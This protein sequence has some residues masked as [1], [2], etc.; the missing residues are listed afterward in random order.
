[1]SDTLGS[2]K[3]IEELPITRIDKTIDIALSLTEIERGLIVK[4]KRA[5]GLFSYESG[6]STGL[7]IGKNDEVIKV[8]SRTKKAKGIIQ[9]YRLGNRL[10][11]KKNDL[12]LLI[13]TSESKRSIQ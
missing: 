11:F 13:E 10:R 8:Y 2:Q 7:Q 4:F 9:E 6:G 1:M 12:D 3:I 5:I